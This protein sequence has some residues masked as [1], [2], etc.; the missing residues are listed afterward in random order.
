MLN[1]ACEFA[2]IYLFQPILVAE[3][4]AVPAGKIRAVEA[5]RLEPKKH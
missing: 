1:G 5:D 4:V 2:G 3:A